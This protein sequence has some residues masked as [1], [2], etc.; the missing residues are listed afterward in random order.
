MN[1]PPIE[2]NRSPD[3][4][5]IE[6]ALRQGVRALLAHSGSPQLDAEVLLGNVLGVDRARRSSRAE[7]ALSPT[8][9]CGRIAV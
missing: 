3:T 2:W 4:S 6:L 7:P 5:T 8:M 1:A 9:P